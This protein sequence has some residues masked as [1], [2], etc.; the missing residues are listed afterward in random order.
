MS[1]HCELCGEVQPTG[2]APRRLVTETRQKS[3]PERRKGT[4]LI[5]AGGKG[6]ETVTEVNACATCAGSDVEETTQA[7]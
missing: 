7:A 3:Y 2:S 5:D 1:F 4:K 6:Y